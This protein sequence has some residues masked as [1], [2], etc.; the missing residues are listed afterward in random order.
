MLEGLLGLVEGLRE[1]GGA[2]GGMKKRK[3]EE[4]GLV[5]EFE[6]DVGEGID[7]LLERAVSTYF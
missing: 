3:R 6:R 2:A 5:D 7:T 1:D 4:E